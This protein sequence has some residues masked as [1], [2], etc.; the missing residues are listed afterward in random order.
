VTR[1]AIRDLHPKVS[2]VVISFNNVGMPRGCIE[3]IFRNTVWP[4]F[5]V[6]VVDNASTDETRAWLRFVA[7]E[8]GDVRVV[9]NAENRGFA[10]ANNQ[11]LAV[12]TGEFL[13]LLNNDTIVPRGWLEP[14]LAQLRQPDV[15]LV[16]PVTN[17]VG[18]EA[19]VDVDYRSVEDME[20]FAQR[21]M[22]THIGEEFDISM[23][24]MFCVALR[25]EVHAQIGDL[26]ECFG[27]GM[28]EDDDY[29]RRIQAAGLRT[30]CT[31]AS[32]VHH[33]GQASFRKLID[34]GE[35]DAL[36]NRNKEIYESKWGRWTQHK[37]GRA[38]TTV[39]PGREQ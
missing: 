15:G 30:V 26:D 32:F 23:L 27:T 20:A 14:L 10:A 21:W 18:N 2:I 38:V 13:V 3:S 11:G 6:I 34:S 25:K 1:E 16:G 24:A 28:F 19:K 4:N 31:P 8:R 7:R 39:R 37:A 17:F 12:A 36:W 33:F 5:E 29:S 35:Y 9:L 22:T